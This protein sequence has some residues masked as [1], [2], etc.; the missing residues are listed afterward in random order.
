M[1][2][3]FLCNGW[4]AVVPIYSKNLLLLRYSSVYST[5]GHGEGAE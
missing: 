1:E 3:P 4:M 2:G 5:W